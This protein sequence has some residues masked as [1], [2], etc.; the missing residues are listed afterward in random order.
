MR[1]LSTTETAGARRGLRNTWR[2]TT[3]IRV[4]ALALSSGIVLSAEDSG[5]SWPLLAALAVIAAASAVFD[6]TSATTRAAW[7]PMAEMLLAALMLAS[8]DASPGLYAYLAAPPVVAGVRYGPVTTINVAFLGALGLLVA[9][10]GSSDSDPRPKFIAAVPWVLSG[11]G[12]GLL[13]G[14]QSRFTRDEE[15]R[16]APHQAAHQLMAQLHD[17]ARRGAVGLDSAQL[18]SELESRLRI[19]TGALVSAVFIS[20]LDDGLI[21]LSS[22]GDTTSLAEEIVREPDDRSPDVQVLTVAGTREVLGFLVLSG[23]QRWSAEIEERALAVTDNFALRLDTAVLFDE[24]RHMAT[25][26]E[27]DRLAREMHDGVA[28][29]IVALGYVVDEIESV[30]AEP[31]IQQLAASLRHELSRVVT[32]LRYSIYD[33]RHHVTDRRLSGAL[34]EYVREISA[35]GDLRVS[36]S[37]DESGPPLSARTETELLRVAQ[38]AIGNVRRHARASNLWVTFVTDGVHIDLDIDDDG[39]GG[40]AAKERHWGLQTMTERAAVIG[41]RLTVSE[42]QSGGT[43][44][45]LYTDH[46]T[47]PEGSAQS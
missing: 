44:V 16:R 17:L 24:V 37:F 2:V 21:P 27:R 30:S 42:R 8:A 13:A 15:A 4:F 12:A 39:I 14:W 11:L 40:A 23:V 22:Y 6:W 32:E 38:E 9:A 35:G 19:E 34:A 36:L 46:S 3:A 26:E 28:Q 31:R 25:A 29:E 1:R 47:A 20:S 33:L 18:A 41:A 45:R 43:T 7:I 10:A 5:A